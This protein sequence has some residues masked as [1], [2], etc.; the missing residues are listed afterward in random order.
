MRLFGNVNDDGDD[1]AE[2]SPFIMV[3]NPDPQGGFR[4]DRDDEGYAD[5]M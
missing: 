3:D 4:A 2:S 5:E 1:D